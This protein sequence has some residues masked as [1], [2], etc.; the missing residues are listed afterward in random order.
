MIANTIET[1]QIETQA[2]TEEESAEEIRRPENV[3]SLYRWIRLNWN[4]DMVSFHWLM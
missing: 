2:D 4:L 1:A 3:N